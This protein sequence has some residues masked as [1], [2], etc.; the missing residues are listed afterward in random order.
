MRR[1]PPDILNR[2]FD[3]DPSCKFWLP[4]YRYGAEQSKILDQSGNQNH[5]VI[6]GAVPA[7]SPMRGGKELVMNGTFSGD[8]DWI[9]GT[10][11]AITTVATKTAGVASDL[12]QDIGAVAST[13]YR[14]LY[15]FSRAAGSITPQ[16]GGVNGIE[17]SVSGIY[18]D[19]ILATG[20]GNLK[21]QGDDA[22][23][24]SVDNASVQKII[25]H[26]GLGWYFDGT[27]DRIVHPAINLGKLHTLHYW[28][29][30]I[31]ENGN[32]HAGA[33]TYVGLRVSDTTVGYSSAS[34]VAVSHNGAASTAK[35]TLITVTRILDKVNFYQDGLHIGDEQTLEQGDNLTLTDFGRLSDGTMYFNGVIYLAVGFT[36]LYPPLE[37]KGY[38]D[39]TRHFLGA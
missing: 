9:K 4:Y 21:F 3:F 28:I 24:G 16:I 37:I 6:T 32:V 29:K 2:Q 7:I 18:E 25:G 13:W 22:L 35:K 34:T 20:T 33:S 23:A 8:T 17:R 19:L 38:Y 11:W 1:D 39:I 5:G 30:R 14:L 15:T 26:E 12:E 31:G 27:D 36:R 10:G